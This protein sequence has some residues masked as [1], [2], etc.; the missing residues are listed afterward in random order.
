SC[1]LSR[2]FSAMAR[3]RTPDTPACPVRMVVAVAVTLCAAAACTIPN[4]LGSLPARLS[5]GE[6]WELSTALSEPQGAFPQSDNLVSNEAQ[7]AETLRNLRPTGGVYIGVGPEQ[8]FSYVARLRPTMAFIV[9]IRRENR[10]L[11]LMYKALFELS[12]D[13]VD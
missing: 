10:N 12:S 11:H 2:W 7:F 13:R 9:D 1:E 4:R 5:D 6:F 3:T 8:N